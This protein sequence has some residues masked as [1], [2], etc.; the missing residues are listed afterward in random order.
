MFISR[1]RLEKIE[2]ETKKLESETKKLAELIG[3]SPEPNTPHFLDS[4]IYRRLT[5]FEPPKRL[6]IIE[7]IQ[8]IMKHLNLQEVYSEEK[9][10]LKVV[11]K[12]KRR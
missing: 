4:Y 1:K 5:D 11:K 10:E 9:T 7:K 3:S 12:P 2:S 6:S 8:M